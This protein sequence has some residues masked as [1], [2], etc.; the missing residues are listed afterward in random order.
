LDGFDTLVHLKG[1]RLKAAWDLKDISALHKLDLLQLD[2]LSCSVEDKSP[3]Y[4][5]KEAA[6]LTAGWNFDYSQFSPSLRYLAIVDGSLKSP[7]ALFS[8]LH[9]FQF[10][11]CRSDSLRS[12]EGLFHV[13]IVEIVQS[14]IEDISGLGGNRSVK[15]RHCT[16]IKDFHAL[17]NIPSVLLEMCPGLSNGHDL[18]NVKYLTIIACPLHDVSP[19]RNVHYLKLAVSVN[20]PAI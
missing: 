16:K 8:Q 9:E 15:I 14:Q 17:R 1:L 12:L 6:S 19:L 2:I 18:E 5:V 20:P 11:G 13:P 3:I 7:P 4:R 10:Y